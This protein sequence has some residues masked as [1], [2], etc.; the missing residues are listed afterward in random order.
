MPRGKEV[1]KK[2]KYALKRASMRRRKGMAGVVMKAMIN[3]RR[4]RISGFQQNTHSHE[5]AIII[6]RQHGCVQGRI[7]DVNVAEKD[8]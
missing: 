4:R 1:M 2:A 5:N 3:A 7:D 8:K 6:V